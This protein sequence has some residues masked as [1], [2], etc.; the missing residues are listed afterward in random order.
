MWRVDASPP[1]MNEWWDRHVIAARITIT[2]TH[3][4]FN[5]FFVMLLYNY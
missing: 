5:S 4:Y 1:G 3:I 2:T